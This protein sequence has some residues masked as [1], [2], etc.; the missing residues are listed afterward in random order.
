MHI[1]MPP[2]YQE[3]NEVLPEH[4]EREDTRPRMARAVFKRAA[5]TAS[6]MTQSSSASF[7]V[8]DKV[9]VID[10]KQFSPLDSFKK[11]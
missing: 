10:L 9:C 11:D 6:V 3:S 1:I 2:N 4:E 8:G 5:G 7:H